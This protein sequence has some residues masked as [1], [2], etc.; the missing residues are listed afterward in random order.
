MAIHFSE[1]VE[2]I[3]DK[4]NHCGQ[5]PSEQWFDED[6]AKEE[7]VSF[8]ANFGQKVYQVGYDDGYY[9]A[10]IQFDEDIERLNNDI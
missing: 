6:G 5:Y 10:S 8:M 4:Y 7:L 9:D 3:L 1:A 2:Q